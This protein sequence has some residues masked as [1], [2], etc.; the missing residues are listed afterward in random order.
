MIL[1]KCFFL[2]P[3]AH[4]GHVQSEHGLPSHTPAIRSRR[5]VLASSF[6]PSI[7]LV[8]IRLQ[9]Q[10]GI[11]LSDRLK[12]GAKRDTKAGKA[13]ATSDAVRRTGTKRTP[14]RRRGRD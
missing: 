12:A 6:L 5:C 8:A 9:I 10:I 4:L 1:E 7:A 13:A 14:R 3:L 2:P 11:A